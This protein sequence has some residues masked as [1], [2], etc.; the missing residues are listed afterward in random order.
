MVVRLRSAMEMRSRPLRPGR[1]R[2]SGRW[3]TCIVQE[4]MGS[5]S[6]TVRGLPDEFQ[7]TTVVNLRDDSIRAPDV[8]RLFRDFSGGHLPAVAPQFCL[9][10]HFAVRGIKKIICLCGQTMRPIVHEL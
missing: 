8:G 9:N 1:P 4:R 10:G 5:P 3:P 7:S 2:R 6:A